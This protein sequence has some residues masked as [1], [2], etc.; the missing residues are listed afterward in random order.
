MKAAGMKKLAT[1]LGLVLAIVSTLAA[2]LPASAKKESGYLL[3]Q[4]SDYWG[5]QTCYVTGTGLY[6]HSPKLELTMF[7]KAPDWQVFCFNS[8]NKTYFTCGHKEWA[9]KFVG[10]T[11]PRDESWQKLDATVTKLRAAMDKGILPRCGDAI[12]PNISVGR[13]GSICG[14][15][16]LQVFMTGHESL[17]FPPYAKS[18]EFWVIPD[19]KF[20]ASMIRA[21][22]ETDGLPQCVGLPIDLYR[23]GGRG[24]TLTQYKTNKIEQVMVDDTLFK[25]PTGYKLAEDEMSLLTDDSGLG[26][27]GLA[28]VFG[29]DLGDDIDGTGTAGKK[30][31]KTS[32][33]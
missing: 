7:M 21:V 31:A 9:Q 1:N 22:S 14:R 16:A 10:P 5:P 6:I 28:D 20:S 29:D 24:K 4:Y 26:K 8:K 19:L 2:C 23:H 18:I 17:L 33:K 25:M 27:G 3:E 30:P 11:G 13:T 12:S 32:A 15:K